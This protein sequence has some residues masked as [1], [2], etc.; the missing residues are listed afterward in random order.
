M[1]TAQ[2]TKPSWPKPDTNGLDAWT[3]A[4]IPLNTQA[5]HSLRL[6]ALK[7]PDLQTQHRR[8]PSNTH[9][10]ALLYRQ[11][12]L[13]KG[14]EPPQTRV[15]LH[16]DGSALLETITPTAK[17]WLV[18]TTP[19]VLQLN[20]TWHQNAGQSD[21]TFVLA[22]P[23]DPDPP[24]PCGFLKPSTPHE[25]PFPITPWAHSSWT[26]QN[27][28]LKPTATCPNTVMDGLG[29]SPV[30]DAGHPAGWPMSDTR[31]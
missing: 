25:K 11:I 22:N 19:W 30:M 28:L 18:T 26:R 4:P 2:K 31:T 16:T 13:W 20:P 23:K 17:G 27:T 21:N 3:L 5:G 24:S 9:Q 12:T 10:D 15:Q 7:R 8:F 6:Q 14:E 1:V 29:R